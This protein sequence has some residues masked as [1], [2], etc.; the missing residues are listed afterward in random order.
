MPRGKKGTGSTED[1]KGTERLV[2]VRVEF[3][4]GVLDR[5]EAAKGIASTE[6]TITAWAPVVGEDGTP[7]V[8]V[9]SKKKVIEEF[10]GKQ[11]DPDARPGTY[12]APPVRSWRGGMTIV[13]P[14][15][16]KPE[17]SLFDD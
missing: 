16:P 5:A 13:L 7:R 3:P 14:E 2:L 11:D 10:A 1:H 17:A 9:G 15:R 8:F 6:K 12:R 4:M